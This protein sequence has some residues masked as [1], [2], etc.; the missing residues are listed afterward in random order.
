MKTTLLF[1]LVI[2]TFQSL[3]SQQKYSK[4]K[5]D[6]STDEVMQLSKLGIDL[7][8]VY[9]AGNGFETIVKSDAI[10]QLKQA[11]IGYEVL[12]DD[13]SAYYQSRN[14]QLKS[15]SVNNLASQPAN[16]E[17]GSMGG[18]Y[19]LTEIM[20]ELD[21]M[22]TLYPHLITERTQISDTLTEEG[23]PIYWLR[24]SDNADSD[25]DEPEILYTAL[26]HAREPISVMQM[27]WHMWYL[28]ENYETDGEIKS[29]VDH[30]E[31]YFIP[32]VNPM[33]M[34]TTK[35]LNPT[36]AACGVK[37][38]ETIKTVRMG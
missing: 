22:R 9:R 25:E 10:E 34:Y 5:L 6:V 16:W 29:L 20:R 26:H 24:I 11:G 2:C 31:M 3:F 38:V 18:F 35:R 37:I 14:T 28:L 36:V 27:I 4:V 8:E 12:I 7:S 1:L 15:A 19:T 13:M 30:T 32:V 33:D 23:R 17:L 21:D